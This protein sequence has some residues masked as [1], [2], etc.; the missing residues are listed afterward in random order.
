[1]TAV[2]RHRGYPYVA[3]HDV[4]EVDL[5][6]AVGIKAQGAFAL[7]HRAEVD[8]LSVR[9]IVQLE[10]ALAVAVERPDPHKDAARSLRCREG[11]GVTSVG[12][13]AEGQHGLPGARPLDNPAA[14]LV[15]LPSECTWGLHL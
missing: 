8:K 1:M 3:S 15:G 2:S 12:R 5:G 14:G 6:A 9:R 7:R 13:V 4:G 11:R 10:V